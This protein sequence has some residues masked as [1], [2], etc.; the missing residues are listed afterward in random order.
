MLGYKGLNGRKDFLTDA[1]GSVTAEVNQACTKTF[2]GRYKPYGGGLS[3]SGTRGKYGW[4]GTWGYREIGLS[5]SSHYVRARIYSETNATWSSYDRFWPHEKGYSYVA[6]RPLFAVDP[7]GSQIWPLYCYILDP[8]NRCTCASVRKRLGLGTKGFATCCGKHSTPCPLQ[9]TLK[10]SPAVKKCQ[11]ES[12]EQ[13]H[14]D[15]FEAGNAQC[16]GADKTGCGVVGWVKPP[17]WKQAECKAFIQELDCISKMVPKVC[18]SGSNEVD[19]AYARVICCYITNKYKYDGKF[20][21]CEPSPAVL[22]Y[23]QSIKTI[24]PL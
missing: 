11:L 10:I 21:D 14:A 3:A 23:C 19:C 7:S 24:C 16:L 1:L 2:E 20:L 17:E 6:S 22:T 13:S 12:H 5:G 9:T 4:V 8:C 18:A 15:D